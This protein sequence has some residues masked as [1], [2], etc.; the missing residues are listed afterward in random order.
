MEPLCDDVWSTRSPTTAHIVSA[1]PRVS[2]IWPVGCVLAVFYA[3]LLPFDFSLTTFHR[4]ISDGLLSL[5]FRPTTPDDAATNLLVYLTVGL[6]VGFC[7]MRSRCARWAGVLLAVVIGTSLSILVEMLQTGLASRVASCTDILLNC[8]GAAIGGCLGVGLAGSVGTA[9]T[10]VRSELADRPFTTAASLLTLGLFLYNLAPFDFVLTTDA[11]HASF[12][13]AHWGLMDARDS[14]VGAS[15]LA[16]MAHELTGG[17]WFAVLGY[18]L[19][20]AGRERRLDSATSLGSALKDGLILVV[21]VEFMQ[22]FTLSHSFDTASIMIRSFGVVCGA[23]C[24]MF[25]IDSLSWSAWRRKPSLAL[26][27]GIVAILAVFQV[28]LLIAPCVNLQDGLFSSKHDWSVQ[29]LPFRNLWRQS[30]LTAAA[31]VLSTLMAFGALALTF[32]VL[33]GRL[34]VVHARWWVLGALTA[35]AVTCEGLRYA[36]LAKRFDCTNTLLA[37]LAAGLIRYAN[38]AVRSATGI[39]GRQFRTGTRMP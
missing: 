39:T 21:L 28:G 2:W 8:V 34:R 9:M 30:F 32:H 37:L 5:R 26:P 38:D 14:T 16:A 31:D 36:C 24:A 15:P 23:W 1:P 12:G 27:T 35:V 20:L 29:W 19:A 18:L 33:L 7:A 3:S 17:G 4:A 13:R 6:V 10:Q 25:L 11:L 22:L